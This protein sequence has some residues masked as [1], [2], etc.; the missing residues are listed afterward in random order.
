MASPHAYHRTD[1]AL[2]RRALRLAA[3]GFGRTS[4]NP[5]VGAVIVR[6]GEIVGEGY[7]VYAKRDHAEV[8]ALNR[9]GSRARGADLFVT[10]EPCSHVGRTPPCVDAILR[11]GVKRVLVAVEDP[12]PLVGGRGIRALREQGVEVVLGLCE[13]EARRINAAFFHFIV[14]RRPYVTL[15]LA[16]TLDGK[17]AT[18]TG[19]SKW[20]TGPQ[21]R[22]L[23]HRFRY[24]SDAILVGIGTVLH[25]DPSLD[26]RWFRR[27]RITKVVLDGDLR[28]PSDARLF[29]S[30]DPVVLF[31]RPGLAES[32]SSAY[33][34]RAD[35]VGAL[36]E[37]RAASWDDVLTEL[38]RRQIV[39]LL[40]EGGA[41]VATS[42]L[43]RGLA[44]RVAFFYGPVLVGADGL[45]G[46]G[47]LGIGRLSQ[48]LRLTELQVRRLGDDVF[49][50]GLVTGSS[51]GSRSDPL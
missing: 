31:H 28:C 18:R 20:I 38:G 14:H 10:L 48:A 37:E 26:V 35:L 44:N 11:A 49:V 43:E 17:I 21:S 39:D 7:H 2:M 22:R 29:E 23:V 27:N 40:V 4:P 45:D 41:Q 30:G 24:G 8:V 34:H 16:L 1:Q 6:D 33:G 9:A 36:Q 12:N 19:D 50:D 42:L 46:V 51:V 5:L 13:Q 32:S 15:K 3:R 25:D 47:N